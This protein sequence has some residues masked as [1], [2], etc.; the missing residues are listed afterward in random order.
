M[1]CNHFANLIATSDQ[2]QDRLI[3]SHTDYKN[4]LIDFYKKGYKNAHIMKGN[5]LGNLISP[6]FLHAVSAYQRPGVLNGHLGTLYGESGD[7]LRSLGRNLLLLGSAESANKHMQ[8]RVSDKFLVN[9]LENSKKIKV[10]EGFSIHGILPQDIIEFDPNLLFS[11][12]ITPL[13]V[14]LDQQLNLDLDIAFCQQL[15]DL[16]FRNNF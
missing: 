2:L 14:N 4:F 3:D 9:F 6:E 10:S 11:P 7:L 8:R 5:S 15:H 13:L 1:G 16:W 12:N